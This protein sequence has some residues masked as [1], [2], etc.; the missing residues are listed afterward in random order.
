M[1]SIHI[2]FDEK[3]FS[4]YYEAETFTPG[5]KRNSSIINIFSVFLKE[6]TLI[7]IAGEH[8]TLLHDI[9]DPG[10]PILFNI[11]NPHNDHEKKLKQIITKAVCKDFYDYG[12]I[13]SD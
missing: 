6:P 7:D 3:T 12:N 4:I 13:N 1:R 8:F 11:K 9:T 10:I 2:F 5:V